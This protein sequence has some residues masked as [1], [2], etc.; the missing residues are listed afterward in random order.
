MRIGGNFVSKF[1]SSQHGNICASI[2]VIKCSEGFQSEFCYNNYELIYFLRGNGKYIVE[3]KEYSISERSVLF[4]RPMTYYC[5]INEANEEIEIASIL[6]DSSVFH[7]EISTMIDG[8]FQSGEQSRFYS[9]ESVPYAVASAFDRIELASSLM[10]DSATEFLKALTSEIIVFLSSQSDEQLEICEQDLGARV[11]RYINANI[12]KNLSLDKLS[13]KFFVSKYYL[14]RAFKKYSGTSVHSYINHKRIMYAKQLI[15][16]GL[17]AS[18][19][20]YEVGF[21]DYSAFYRAYVKILGKSPMA[22]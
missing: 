15:D 20:A 14:C 4:L 12:D 7:S 3:G 9:A 8:I 5:I 6:F 13:K 18:K 21:G 17:T 10:T 16:S 19:A 2:S 11:L 22:D 1:F